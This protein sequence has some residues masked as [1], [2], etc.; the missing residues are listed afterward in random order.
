MVRY[1][2]LLSVRHKG[3]QG[4][5]PRPFYRQGKSPL[6]FGAGAGNTAG[7]YFTPLGD[8]PAQYIRILIVYLKF[9]GAEFA[10]LLLKKNLSLSA[11]AA[12]IA[13][14]AVHGAIPPIRTVSA[15]VSR[16]TAAVISRNGSRPLSEAPRRPF[17]FGIL[18]FVRHNSPLLD[19][20]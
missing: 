10:D 12:V 7:Q 3:K 11:P 14:P 16:G 5:N 20:N 17:I 9:L 13:V 2:I 19:K 15:V 4:D 6:M 1:P 18:L 8:K